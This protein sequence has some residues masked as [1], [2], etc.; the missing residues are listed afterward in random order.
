[1]LDPLADVLERRANLHEEFGQPEKSIALLSRAADL[2]RASLKAAAD[3]GKA[4]G[5]LSESLW[6]LARLFRKAGREPDA[7]GME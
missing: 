6:D 1:M 4:R 3:D 5:I 2:A 7:A